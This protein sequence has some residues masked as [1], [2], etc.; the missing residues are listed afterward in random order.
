MSQNRTNKA[1]NVDKIDLEKEKDKV[2]DLPGLI[3][4]AH[5]VGSAVIK[6]EDMGKVKGKAVAA[7]Q[8]QTDAQMKQLYDQMKTL[9][10]QANGIKE[11][12][13][14]SIRIY[15]SKMNFEPVIGHIYYVY[16]KK[17]GSDVLSMIS[18]E[19]W[20]P[21]MPFASCLATVKLLADHTWEVVEGEIN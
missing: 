8:E 2:A 6:P 1:I 18:P 7:M 21:S 9:V 4:F 12:I 5:N 3:E 19:E 13:S 15:Q 17:D 11:R 10:T 20:G 16:N 14:I